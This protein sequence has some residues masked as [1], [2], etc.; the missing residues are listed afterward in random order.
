MFF[1]KKRRQICTSQIIILVWFCLFTFKAGIVESRP[2]RPIGKRPSPCWPPYFLDP[3]ICNPSNISIT[4]EPIRGLTEE[5]TR[6]GKISPIGYFKSPIGYFKS[7]IGYI[8]ANWGL[9]TCSLNLCYQTH[10]SQIPNSIYY[11]Q[12]GIWDPQLEIICQIGDIFC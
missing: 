5:N 11:P 8:L 2:G 7:P 4:A 9:V 12:L 10:I 6:L 1:R 3:P